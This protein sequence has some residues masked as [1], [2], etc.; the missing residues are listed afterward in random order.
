MPSLGIIA[1]GGFLIGRVAG[2]TDKPAVRV[3][4]C[5]PRSS[6][7]PARLATYL[8]VQPPTAVSRLGICCCVVDKHTDIVYC[9]Y[10]RPRLSS[11]TSLRSTLAAAHDALSARAS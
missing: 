11:S 4:A 10:A 6:C 5:L 1:S 2:W 7:L 8:A 9:T 3:L